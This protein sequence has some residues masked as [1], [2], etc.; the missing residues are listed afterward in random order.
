MQPSYA[1]DLGVGGIE[2][3]VHDLLFPTLNHACP[4]IPIARIAIAL[5]LSSPRIRHE[6]SLFFVSMDSTD[7]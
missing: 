1:Q 3:S 6:P 7:Q 4:K 5:S 2:V